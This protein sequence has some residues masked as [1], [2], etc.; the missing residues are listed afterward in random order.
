ML[1]VS[2]SAT[3]TAPMQE[4]ERTISTV[5][6]PSVAPASVGEHSTVV[7]EDDEAMSY[8]SKLANE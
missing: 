5:S 4:S 2:A 7:E 1:N 8:F 6:S 3:P